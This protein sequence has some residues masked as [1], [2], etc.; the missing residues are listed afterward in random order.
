MHCIYWKW[1][2]FN[3]DFMAVLWSGVSFLL[4]P[5]DCAGRLTDCTLRQ[6]ERTESRFICQ[7]LIWQGKMLLWQTLSTKPGSCETPLAFSAIQS[8][9]LSSYLSCQCFKPQH[10]FMIVFKYRKLWI[11]TSSATW[12]LYCQ[13]S[14]SSWPPAESMRGALRPWGM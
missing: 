11:K 10:S 8:L 4:D 9:I 13:R 2:R 6:V 12:V 14:K 3:Q 7:I 5:P 1:H